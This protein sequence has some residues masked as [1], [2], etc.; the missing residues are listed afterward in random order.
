M[1]RRKSS[2]RRAARLA[3]TASS[4]AWVI[5]AACKPPAAPAPAVSVDCASIEAQAR[6]VEHTALEPELVAWDPA[7]RAELDRLRK[8]GVVAVRYEAH[9]CDVSLELLPECVG[10]KNRYVFMP[11]RAAERE[12]QIAHDPGELFAKLPLGATTLTSLFRDGHAVVADSVIVGSVGL[13]PGSTVTETDLV[14]TACRRATHV[15]GAVYFGGFALASAQPSQADALGGLFSKGGADPIAHEGYPAICE[16]AASEGVE[17]GGCSVPLRLALI[18]LHP[19]AAR[20]FAAPP[21]SAALD[22]GASAD[23]DPDASFDQAAIE[24]IVRLH[25]TNVRKTCFES[26]AESVKRVTVSVSL[27]VDVHGHVA[28]ADPSVT[29][30]DG[31]SDLSAAVGRCIANDVKSWVFPEPDGERVLSLPFHFLRQ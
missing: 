5:S 9:G 24:R 27:K 18:S 30:A 17:L 4:T 7:A 1:V 22:A 20:I 14:G 12:T 23:Q 26:A 8:Q 2:P 19:D 3:F 6:A 29:E 13:P 15:V 16:R 10:P 28:E 31:P 25:Q 21:P 11:V